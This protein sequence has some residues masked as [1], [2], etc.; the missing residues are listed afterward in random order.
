M[1]RLAGGAR[2]VVRHQIFVFG[3]NKAMRLYLSYRFTGEDP[4]ILADIMPKIQAALE[5]G[6]H[7]TFCSL[8]E[9]EE[10]RQKQW[11]HKRIMSR[12]FERLNESDG[13][14][15]LVRTSDKS[16]GQLLEIGYGLAQRK[17][18]ILAIH[19]HVPTV[20]L[21]EL[22]DQVIEYDNLDELYIKLEKLKRT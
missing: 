16:E 1:V 7:R 12:A 11:S 20:F 14:F 13:C 18:L 22:A 17:K 2:F 15:A 9:L 4:Q 5:R 10:Y 3:Y 6:G 19:R 8:N 21:R